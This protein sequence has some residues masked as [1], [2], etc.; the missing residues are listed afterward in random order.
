MLRVVSSTSIHFMRRP[1]FWW[2]CFM[3]QAQSKSYWVSSGRQN[4]NLKKIPKGASRKQPTRKNGNIGSLFKIK[5]LVID[6]KVDLTIL[7]V[8]HWLH[9]TIFFFPLT[10][11]SLVRIF[12]FSPCERSGFGSSPVE[13]IWGFRAMD[14]LWNSLW[15]N[16]LTPE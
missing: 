3:S 16:L 6:A 4:P 15:T 7:I 12:W 8:H 11:S 14:S 1:Q 2:P 5:N 10:G 13:R 9:Q